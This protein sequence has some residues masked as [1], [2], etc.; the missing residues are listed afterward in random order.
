MYRASVIVAALGL[1]LGGAACRDPQ[2]EELASVRAQ[3]CACKTAACGEE[4]M[5]RVPQRDGWSEH[6]AQQI[7]KAMMDCLAKLYVED[8]PSTD[9]D[10]ETA[11]PGASAA[12]VAGSAAGPTTGSA[13]GST[14]GAAGSAGAAAGS[15]G[16]TGSAPPAAT[17]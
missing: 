11:D 12:E 16:A 10:A 15:A 8:R 6:R 14:G 4:A 9:P 7:A 1:G 2:L 3:V 5:K 13:A 17:P